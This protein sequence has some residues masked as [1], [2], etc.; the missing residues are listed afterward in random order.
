[1]RALSRRRIGSGQGSC[2][3]ATIRGHRPQVRARSGCPGLPLAP[4]A[5]QN[6]RSAHARRGGGHCGLYRH[7]RK[8][9]GLRPYRDWRPRVRVLLQ[10]MASPVSTESSRSPQQR[11]A[12]R[13]VLIV[14]AAGRDFHNFNV[15][16]RNDPSVEVV[17]FTAAQI[18]GIADRRYPPALGGP[19]LS[20][21]NSDRCG[22]GARRTVPRM[23]RRRGRLRLQR[24][25]PRA[26]DAPCFASARSRRRLHF[27]RAETHRCCS[28]ACR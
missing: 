11:S 24:R 15:V 3:R 20:R 8:V 25:L 21:G 13:R 16:Y 6:E 23:V 17:A 12:R 26:R 9:V 5:S 4:P 10:P 27:A 1:M 18:P 22:G 7:A 19:A 14:G 28:R 2:R